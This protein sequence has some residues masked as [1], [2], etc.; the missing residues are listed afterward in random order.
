MLK[1]VARPEVMIKK[2]AAHQKEPFMAQLNGSTG[3]QKKTH[4]VGG[5]NQGGRANGVERERLR[6][7]KQTW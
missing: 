7:C 3:G 2:V 1:E 6:G 4:T 5:A